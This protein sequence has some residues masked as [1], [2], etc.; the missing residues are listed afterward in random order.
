MSKADSTAPGGIPDHDPAGTTFPRIPLPVSA[1]P[2]LQRY[3]EAD[4]AYEHGRRDGACNA[5]RRVERA[6]RWCTAAEVRATLQALR[7]GPDHLHAV[8]ASLDDLA[9][10]AVQRKAGEQ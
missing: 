4:D 2:A 5:L 10:D 9:D 1:D 6:L 7:Q 3:D 8:L